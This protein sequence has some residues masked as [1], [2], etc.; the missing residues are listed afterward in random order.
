MGDSK[1]CETLGALISP[2]RIMSK[3]LDSDNGVKRGLNIWHYVNLETGKG[4]RTVI[5][6]KSASAKKGV[7]FN[8]CPFC[9]VEYPY[10]E[11][12][13]KKALE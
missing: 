12:A 11:S 7:A 5:G 6:V 3:Y 1:R 9:G 8:F 4:T 13:K 2:C 10:S